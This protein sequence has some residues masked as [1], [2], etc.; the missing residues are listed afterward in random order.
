MRHVVAERGCTVCH[1]ESASPR[2]PEDALPLAPGWREIAAR[3]RG[4]ADAE[5]ALTRIV[6]EGADPGD[7]HW[8]DRIDFAAMRG[9]APG[10]T[11][12]EA[13]AL[14]RWILSQP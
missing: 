2:G 5:E 7:R 8:K 9:N 3:Y 12:D 1:R 10:V 14:V 13:R 11:P 4:R 6:I